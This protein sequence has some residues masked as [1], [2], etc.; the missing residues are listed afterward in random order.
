MRRGISPV[1]VLALI[2]VVIIALVL[3]LVLSRVIVGINPAVLNR[4]SGMIFFV[5]FIVVAGI[6]VFLVGRYVAVSYTH[7][8]LP[9]T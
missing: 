9:T 5:M 1:K 3:C 6:G 8:T 4:W 7:L 2:G